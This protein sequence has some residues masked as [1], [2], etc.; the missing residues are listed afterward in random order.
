MNGSDASVNIVAA[1][2]H[3]TAHISVPGLRIV[4]QDGSMAIEA[5]TASGE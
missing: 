5:Q 3:V 1:Q 4:L 2:G